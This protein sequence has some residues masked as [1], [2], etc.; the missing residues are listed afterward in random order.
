MATVE[1]FKKN[2][3][4]YLGLKENPAGSNDV[5]G[6]TDWYGIKGPWCAML[7]SKLGFDIGMPV[8]AST[9]KGFAY[10]PAGVAYFKQHNLWA[11][12]TATPQVGWF[13]FYQFT[14][15]PDHVGR[16]WEVKGP[17]H[18]VAIEGNTDEAGGRTGGKC[19]LKDRSKGIIGYGIVNFDPAV[20]VPPRPTAPT[21]AQVTIGDPEGITQHPIG[22]GGWIY[23]AD[24]AVYTFGDAKYFGGLTNK[25]LAAPVCGLVATPTGNGYWMV[26]EDGGIFAFGDAV[27]IKPYAPFQKEWS[28]GQRKAVGA[29]WTGQKT[30]PETWALT[31]VSNHLEE[32]G[33]TR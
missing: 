11:A 2:A 5:K 1:E 30:K 19:M 8:P 6:V 22:K 10:V 21:Q 23:S 26:G 29:V 28:A 7:A 24:G 33:L 4:K 17:G 12:S 13:V 18:I 27:G 15:R 3:E 16:V 25:Q 32:Y 14:N 31:M 9:P 20:V